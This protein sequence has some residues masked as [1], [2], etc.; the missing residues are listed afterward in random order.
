M[1]ASRHENAIP[2]DIEYVKRMSGL[3]GEYSF[4]EL[5]S[6]KRIDGSPKFIT[7]YEDASNML[8]DCKQ[9]A[10][11]ETERE[12]EREAETEPP[13]VPP[14]DGTG[15]SNGLSKIQS[16]RFEEFNSM[17]PGKRRNKGKARAVWSRLKPT[18]EL[19]AIIMDSLRK[20]IACE[21]WQ[22]EQGQ[23]IP[24][25]DVWLR[26]ERWENEPDAKVVPKGQH[27]GDE[28]LGF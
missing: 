20:H 12:R 3:V 28:E 25:A 8:A 11:P 18:K 23:Y 1:L 10:I 21:D 27:A 26:G 22:K 7:V 9:L 16:E 17:Y 13:I 6:I 14:G 19:F 2:Y 15:K 24:G 5:K 4:D